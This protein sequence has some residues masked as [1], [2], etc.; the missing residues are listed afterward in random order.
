MSSTNDLEG[1]GQATGAGLAIGA[2]DTIN[3]L[4][5]RLENQWWVDAKVTNMAGDPIQGA[6]VEVQPLNSVGE[7]R[8][9]STNLQGTFRTDY[10]LR[11]DV[12]KSSASP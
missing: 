1:Q 10:W 4:Q 5:Q 2:M 11:V 9:F 8:T 6:T 7:F 12:S 3:N